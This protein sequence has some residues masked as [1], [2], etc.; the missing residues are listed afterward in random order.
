[1]GKGGTVFL[2]RNTLIV[3]KNVFIVP[4]I[5]VFQCSKINVS[6]AQ[7]IYTGTEYFLSLK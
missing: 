4:I 2:H 7:N 1:M 3:D 6:M 5:L